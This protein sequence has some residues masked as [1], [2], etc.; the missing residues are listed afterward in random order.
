MT[1]SAILAFGQTEKKEF[2]L[3]L[4]VGREPNNNSISDKKVGKYDFIKHSRCAFWNI[5]FKLFG[6]FNGLTTIQIKQLFLQQNAS[7]LIFTDASPKGIPNEINDKNAI[8][9]TLTDEEIIE[10]VDAIFAN[11]EILKRVKLVLLSGLEDKK[12]NKFKTLFI[13]QASKRQMPTKEI[14]FLIGNNYAKIERQIG[15]K[16]IMLFKQI[17]NSFK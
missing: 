14:A 2:P 4:V 7:P 12:Y 6:I 8:R 17:L 1:H 15:D 11:V 9:L 10:H 16:E 3:I 5:S 13:Q